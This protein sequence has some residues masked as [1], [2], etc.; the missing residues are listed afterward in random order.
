[1]KRVKTVV[2]RDSRDE[3]TGAIVSCRES[4]NVTSALKMLE[5]IRKAVTD[6]VKVSKNGQTAWAASSEDFNFGDL[7]F[8]FT[9]SDLKKFLHRYGIVD[10]NV[11][12]FCSENPEVIRGWAYDTIL[13]DI[14]KL[15]G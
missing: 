14:E 5:A 10:L 11:W 6:W 8:C 12:T 15:E 1:M 4:K 3:T 13:V 9:D 7:S 2:M